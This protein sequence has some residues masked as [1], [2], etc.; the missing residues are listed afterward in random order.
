M[1]EKIEDTKWVIR[2]SQSK[3]DRQHNGQQKKDK[4]TNT[5]LQNTTQKTKDWVTRTSPKTESKFGC[6]GSVSA[7]YELISM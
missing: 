1:Q 3:K 2:S 7:N 5:Y 4:R 6:S